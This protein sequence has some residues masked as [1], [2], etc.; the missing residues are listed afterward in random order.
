FGVLVVSVIEMC[1]PNT[2]GGRGR[3]P[4]EGN[5][6][7][8]DGLIGQENDQGLEANKGVKGVNENVK[9]VNG[10]VGGAPY[11]LTIISYQLQNLLPSV[12][13]QV[14]NKGNVRNQNGNVVNENIQENVRNVLVNGNRA[15]VNVVELSDPHAKL[16]SCC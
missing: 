15:G 8:V 13:D 6:E 7:C 1:K 11:F 16:G 10:S 9:G 12:L 14:G 2:K 3:R 4:K 5:D